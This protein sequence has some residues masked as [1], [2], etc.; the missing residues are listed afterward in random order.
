[1]VHLLRV[2]HEH[3]GHGHSHESHGLE[4]SFLI[5]AGLIMRAPIVVLPLYI[6][7]MAREMNHDP[8]SFGIL[9]SLPLLMFVLVS[10]CVPWLVSRINLTRTMQLGSAVIFIGCLMRMLMTWPTMLVA[11]AL[12]GAGIAIL[13]ISMPTMVSERF[14]HK[15]GLYTTAYSAGMVAGSVILV[16]IDPFVTD[17]FGWKAMM[18]LMVVMAFIPMFLSFF[19][20]AVTVS[21]TVEKRSGAKLKFLKDPRTWLFI[22]MFAGQ[23]FLSY[24]L[25]AWLP[26]MMNADHVSETSYTIVNVLFN[27]AGMPVSLIIPLFIARTRRRYHIYLLGTLTAVQIAIVALYRWHTEMGEVYWYLFGTIACLFFT[28]IFVMALTFYPI[29]SATSADTADISGISQSL[30]YL[31]ASTGPV[32]YGAMYGTDMPTISFAWSM[33][34]AVL[35]TAW[36]TWQVIRINK[37]GLQMLGRKKHNS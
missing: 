35:V 20:P 21:T 10:M 30:G 18:W 22:G 14:S 13:N 27:L 33:A 3:R 7:Q 2:H 6:V 9:T 31:I 25:S 12:V 26:S 24:T 29:K 28:T 23:S 16:M 17:L 11:T 32:M 36:C 8:Q 19:L 1:M 37:F 4:A 5:L 15:P 34:I